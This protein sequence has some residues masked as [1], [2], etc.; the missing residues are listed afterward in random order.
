M[1]CVGICFAA[2]GLMLIYLPG[3]ARAQAPKV[4]VI[5]KDGWKIEGSVDAR[6]RP[7]ETL[8]NPKAIRPLL[9]PAKEYLVLLQ[10]GATYRLDLASAEISALLVVKDLSGRQLALDEGSGGDLN[11]RLS[12]VPP[13][14]GVYKVYA[15]TLK[16]AGKFTL[17]VRGELVTKGQEVGKEGLRIKGTLSGTAKK[18][19]YPVKLVAGKTYQID[20]TSP[21]IMA[22]DPYLRLLDNA[23]KQL[24][25]NDDIDYKGGNLNSRIIFMA[26]ATGIYQIVATSFMESGVG[27]YNLEVREKE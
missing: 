15:A 18:R 4:H 13:K 3:S 20:M 23:G 25:E 11:A 10:G 14:N 22:L 5:G 8:P 21:N 7:V 9:L 24:A 26:P 17:S 12:F 1:R 19:I 16:G 27:E 6:D 2:L